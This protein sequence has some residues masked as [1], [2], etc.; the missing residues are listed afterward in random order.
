FFQAE[1]GIRDGHVT[2]V[3]TCAL[4]I[5]CLPLKNAPF[6]TSSRTVSPVAWAALGT[7]AQLGLRASPV[8][9]WSPEENRS[10]GPHSVVLPRPLLGHWLK[11]QALSSQE[12][13]RRPAKALA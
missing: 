10:W 3:Q 2:G 11:P 1:D 13:A 5:Y 6:G 4:P 8:R 12:L 9:T 7:T